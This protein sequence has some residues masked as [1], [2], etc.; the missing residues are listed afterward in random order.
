MNSHGD[1]AYVIGTEAQR[2]AVERIPGF[3]FLPLSSADPTAVDL[4][5]LRN[6]LVNPSFG[7]SPQNVSQTGNPAAAAAV[8]GA[9]C[10][11][12]RVCAL[13]ILAAGGFK[14]CV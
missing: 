14:A 1:Y 2:A 11:Q 6:T 12:A 7:N 8:M 4:L 9:C 13:S 5:V 10:R 3:A